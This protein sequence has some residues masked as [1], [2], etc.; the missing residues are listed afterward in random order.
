MKTAVITGA[1]GA[2]GSYL[3]EALEKQGV[4]CILV[5]RERDL[6]GRLTHMLD[7]NR[8]FFYK[9]DFTNQK[10]IQNVISDI[11]SKHKKI[12]YLFNVAGIGIYKK[13]EDLTLSEWRASMDINLNSVFMFSKGLLPLFKKSEDAMVLSFGSGMG[14]Y[15]SKNRVA[16]CTSKFA[17][18]GM[19][20]TLSKEFK[21]RGV[22]FVLL[23]LGSVMTD[24]GTGGL[25][26]RKKLEQNGK[27]YLNV[28]EVIDK[29]MQIT[30]SPSRSD[31]YPLYPEGYG[32]ES[33]S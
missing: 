6:L 23:T 28:D 3:V 25:I 22:D 5:E 32:N 20:L 30:N 4:T 12:D 18:R 11:T 29:V 2:M 26:Y 19:S 9:A 10:D 31:E 14:I 17:L 27:K 1:G 16:Y 15:P 24:F 7:G 33:K 21:G 8:H 13:L